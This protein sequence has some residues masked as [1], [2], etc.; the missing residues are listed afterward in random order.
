MCCEAG[1]LLYLNEPLYFYR[2][3]HKPVLSRSDDIRRGYALSIEG[4]R[5]VAARLSILDKRYA[6]LMELR[7]KLLASAM[8]YDLLRAAIKDGD[9]NAVFRLLTAN[10]AELRFLAFRLTRSAWRCVRERQGVTD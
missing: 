9:A 1:R 4:N 7:E 8:R 10:P 5:I 3:C 2:Y 6:E